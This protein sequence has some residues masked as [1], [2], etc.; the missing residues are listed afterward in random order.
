MKRGILHTEKLGKVVPV[1]KTALQNA[2]A[3]F[4]FLDIWFIS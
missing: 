1:A 4:Y 2:G 3:E